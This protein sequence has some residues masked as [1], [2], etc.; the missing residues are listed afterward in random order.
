MYIKELSK[1]EFD[2]FT[3]I[4]PI[5]SI[6]QTSEYGNLMRNQGYSDLYIG[7]IKDN[8][9]IASSLILIRK[10][11]GF[12]YGYVPR[13][14]LLNYDDSDLVNE[15]TKLLKPFLSKL[16]IMGLKM[17]PLILKNI[18]D[19]KNNKVINNSSFNKIFDTLKINDYSHLGYNNFFEALKP[20]FEAII[21]LNKP[22][23]ELFRNIKKEY[24]TKIRSAIKNGIKVYKCNQ[25]MLDTLFE[26][27]KNKYERD[28]NYFKDC[29]GFFYKNNMIDI[30][31]TKLDPKKYLEVVQQKLTYHENLGNILNKKIA[32]KSNNRLL[33][34]KI[35]NDKYIELYKKQLIN[36]INILKKHQKEVVT[37]VVLVI[38][39]AKEAYILIDGYDTFYKNLNSKH[40]LI[41]QLIEIYQKQGFK[42]LNL[43]GIT[44]FNINSKHNGL[45]QFKLNFSPLVYEYIGDLELVTNKISYNLYRNYVP[46]KN[47][48]KD[49]L[50]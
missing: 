6:Y 21:I 47:L 13:G 4:Y 34:K 17:C 33:N 32:F 15:F 7:L 3:N 42:T 27:T 28:L 2:N 8:K 38:K 31:C 39:Q 46:F 37:S 22:I 24:K 45:N 9:I 10:E 44:N 5:K 23:E 48:I 20:R 14:F 19:I 16:G 41:W 29:Y 43:G 18:Y 35:S 40:L 30:Y 26:F 1:Q 36:A 25:N 12:K 49:K 11:S 50:K